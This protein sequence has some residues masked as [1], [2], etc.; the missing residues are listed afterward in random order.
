MSMKLTKNYQISLFVIGCILINYAGKLTAQHLQLPLWL[1]SVGTAM[2]AYVLGPV[3]GSI[4]GATVNIIYGFSNSVSY[5]YALT[6]AAEAVII[7]LAA[8]KK[9]F[10]N[11]FRTITVSVM[12]AIVSV[13]VS[14]PLN[15]IFYEGKT[16]NI[17]GEGVMALLLEWNLPRP[18]TIAVGEFYIDF[19]DKL[20]T[21][22]LLFA[23]IRIHRCYKGKREKKAI[24]NLLAVMTTAFGI[25]GWTGETLANPVSSENYNSYI[26]TVFDADDGLP[27]G[28]AN[29]ILAAK[30]G[31]LWVGT[32]SGLYRYNGKEFK[33]MREFQSVKNVKCLFSDEEGRLWIGT[34]DSGVSVCINEQ[35]AN[36]I[37]SQNGLS[38]DS[39]TCI[40]K[41]ED[42]LYYIGTTDCLQMLSL[43]NGF[44]IKATLSQ[45]KYPISI[46]SDQNGHI[47]VV[48]DAGELYILEDQKILQ[49]IKRQDAENF[50]CCEFD[51]QGRLYVGTITDKVQTYEFSLGKFRLQRTTVCDLLSN[52]NSIRVAEDDKL[53]LCSDTGIGYLDENRQYHVVNTNTFNSS[54]DR[55]TFDY[56]GNL[57]FSS[58]R[59]GLLR[60]CESF[61]KDVYS[62]AGLE[63][64]VV[65]SVV[66][67]QDT[68]YFGTDNGMDAVSADFSKEIENELTGQFDEVRIR[69][70]QVDTRDHLWIST[71]GKG[72]FEV[73][74]SGE[75]HVYDS[76][77][78][79][80]GEKFRMT[81][82]LQDGSIAAA[83]DTGITFIQNGIVTNVI[84]Y[85]Q[86]LVNPKVLSLMQKKDGTI[87]AATN[88]GGI[89]IIKDGK[90]K[91]VIR[92]TDGLGSDVVL[93]TVEDS[94]GKG[95]FLV[96]SNGLRYM[97]WDYQIKELRHFPCYNNYDI[98][99]GQKGKLFIL[100]SNG[101][102]VAEEEALIADEETE[103]ELIDSRK[104]LKDALTANSWNYTDT[105]GTCYLCCDK[106]VNF[107]DL[108]NYNAD[109]R[110]YRMRVSSINIDGEKHMVDKDEPTRLA[111]GAK[112]IEI[113]P[114]VVNYSTN[115]PWIR[116]YLEGI[117][118]K[119][120]FVHQSEL[121]GV[122]YT[123][124]P[125]GVY[126]FHMAVMD[127]GRQKVIEE[128]V[129][130]IIKEKEIYDHWWFYL[131]FVVVFVLIVTWFTWFITRAR[132]QK[133]LD[134]QK[135]ELELVKRQVEMGNETILAIAK[136][137]DAKDENTSQHSVRVS[138]YSVM[139]AEKLGF[140]EE[141]CENLRKTA[142]LHD[143]GK[144]G[145]PDRVLNKPARLD[146]AEYEIMKT[147][148]VK[149]AQIL[150]DFTLVDHVTDGVLYHHERF[151]GSGY[152]QGLVGEHI[153][154]NARIIGVA[155]AFDAM[156]ANRVYRRKIPFEAVL[157]EL[158]NG[159]GTQ[160]DPMLVDILLELIEEGTID[161]RT[162]YGED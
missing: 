153:P 44:T 8:Q 71:S 64:A 47:A 144:I 12:V 52:L 147:H 56:Q 54:I 123:N 13:A 81:L 33:L 63:Q 96:A 74:P 148:V 9:V 60:L 41:G 29:D 121:S 83:G 34:N 48:T 82:E 136:T 116:Y 66:K 108:N 106:G 15:A 127:G 53:F 59:L 72:V 152:A 105:D 61:F 120:F 140:S 21:V 78:G 43:N 138:E 150:K 104:G 102:Y 6:N 118:E 45:V 132:M 160:F 28:G 99:K 18:L 161:V 38:S 85:D 79:A 114:E 30:D 4:V 101:V 141:E 131:Y 125:T 88:G 91:R 122:S 23:A 134:L 27:G 50:S 107:L 68:L 86:G 128:S 32:Y 49:C 119:P 40:N 20:L 133:M 36:V 130:E 156:T 16:S 35:V 154:L 90:L 77:K 22:M 76:A 5:I 93:R 69:C 100:C 37:D 103:Y 46:S 11:L 3:C 158:H 26:Q 57:W 162:I 94:E 89:A 67:W 65:N 10:E 17:W 143:I 95:V 112:R 14:A 159:R 157:E 92:K 7:G 62:E 126:R 117:D 80:L 115:D 2:A 146:D 155:D 145:I 110:S 25:F 87:L 84:G 31:V 55:M 111:R 39:V 137:V 149:G 113:F 42:G 151:D 124:L 139:I 142:L 98:L 70:L 1:D 51:A 97:T 58:S 73:E 109:I 24:L 19:I 75:L 135:R 129:Y